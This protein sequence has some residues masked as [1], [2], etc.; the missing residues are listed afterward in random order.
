M[1]V[2]GYREID[3]RTG[4]EYYKG[5][6]NIA[7]LNAGR[8]GIYHA[9]KLSGCKKILLPYYQ[10]STVKRFLKYKK[11][12]QEF[13]HI[14]ENFTPLIG[15]H[16]KDVAFLIVNY[17]GLIKSKTLLDLVNNNYN[18]II[19]N[20]QGFFQ[21]PIDCCYNVY[22]PRKF[23]GVPDG[24]YIIGKSAEEYTNIYDRDISAET[25]GFLLSRIESGGNNNYIQ[26]LE[27]EKRIDESDI[28]RM[29]VL[30][31]HLLDNIDYKYVK[32]KRI[33]NYCYAKEKF[34]EINLID[35]KLLEKE[36][37]A[38]PMVYPLILED[39]N[40]R[41]RLKENNIFVGQWWKYILDWDDASEWEKYVSRYM[42]PVQIDQRY[43]KEEIDY[44]YNVI[45][46]NIS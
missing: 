41:F 5:D 1:E 27:N 36:T 18:V 35:R 45:T 14:S 8:C 34:A 19:D 16:N 22:S 43:G 9:L 42:I 32:D 33:A 17:F 11:I 6:T 25:A 15:N 23:I 40:L 29:S 30:T 37:T 24:C 31:R 10:C 44:Q 46:S 39:P 4:F 7:R 12:E 2:G 20:T 21:S 38:V 28:L 26:Y 3:L 13:Y